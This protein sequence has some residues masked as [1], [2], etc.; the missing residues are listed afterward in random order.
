[1]HTYD[2]FISYR[3]I[4]K[5]ECDSTAETESEPVSEEPVSKK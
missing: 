3:K 5:E 4:P 2:I 1:M